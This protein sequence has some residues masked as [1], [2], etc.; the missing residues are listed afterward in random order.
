M[1]GFFL[2]L[3]AIAGSFVLTYTL[4]Y[5]MAYV[6]LDII[7]LYSIPYLVKLTTANIFGLW[8]A[9]VLFTTRRSELMGVLDNKSQKDR[10][11]FLKDDLKIQIT[12]FVYICLIWGISII[13]HKI[14]F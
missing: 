1:K 10:S 6:T 5:F 14:F 8:F 2:G 3:I 11:D 7:R 4:T 12:Y 9:Y 13:T